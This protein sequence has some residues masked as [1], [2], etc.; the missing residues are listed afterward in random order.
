MACKT[1]ENH[2]RRICWHLST[3]SGWIK[4]PPRHRVTW[5]WNDNVD[6]AVKEK[7]RLRKSWKQG[8]SKK[9]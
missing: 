5:W 7:G 9:G 1:S 6:I 8:G 4:G 2:F 3:Q